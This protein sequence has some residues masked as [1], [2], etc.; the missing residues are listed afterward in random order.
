MSFNS[1]LSHKIDIE[2]KPE[3]SIR[4]GLQ[5]KMYVL[6]FTLNKIQIMIGSHPSFKWHNIEPL[7][8]MARFFMYN[9]QFSM[10]GRNYIT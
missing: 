6:V 9:L 8:V 7:R 2:T 3:Q 4:L 1:L 5:V 10:I